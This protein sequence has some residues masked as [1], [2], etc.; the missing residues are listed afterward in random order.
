MVYLGNVVWV[1]HIYHLMFSSWALIAAIKIAVPCP[2]N[3]HLSLSLSLFLTVAV[4]ASLTLTFHVLSFSICLSICS[5]C[6]CSTSFSDYTCTSHLNPPTCSHHISP[7]ATYSCLYVDIIY[8]PPFNTSSLS[9]SPPV[10]NPCPYVDQYS[11]CPELKKEW[12]CSNKDVASWCPAS[13]KCTNQIV[14]AS[15]LTASWTEAVSRLS[16]QKK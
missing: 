5:P 15:I 8:P 9:L 2:H 14:W 12:G 4:A 16:N 3:P 1:G 11:N 7:H 13:C 6:L 10:A